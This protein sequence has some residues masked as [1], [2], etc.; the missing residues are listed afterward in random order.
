MQRK[1]GELVPIG[2]V[3]FGLDDGP[4]KALAKTSPQAVHHFTSFANQCRH[5]AR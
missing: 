4:M 1:C 2:E 3:V 5:K